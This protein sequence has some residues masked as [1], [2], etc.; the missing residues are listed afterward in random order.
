MFIVLSRSEAVSR[1]RLAVLPLESSVDIKGPTNANSLMYASR[2][3]VD[4]P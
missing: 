3:V 2:R 4:H 1:Q